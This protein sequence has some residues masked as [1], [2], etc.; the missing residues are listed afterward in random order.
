MLAACGADSGA[1]AQLPSA[2]RR[3]DGPLYV[4]QG[5][6]GAA[7]QVVQCRNGAIAGGFER[8]GVYAEGATSET[9]PDALE[10]AYSEGMFLE[11]PKVD[12]AVART[13]TDR[14]LLTYADDA[15]AVKVAIV[16][17]DGPGTEGAG[18]DGWYR[19]SWARCDLS[20]FPEQ[21][22]RSYFGYQIWTGADGEPALT[23]AIV[24]FPGSEHCGW[25][26]TTFLSLGEGSRDQALYAR[27]PQP[28]LEPL[29]QGKY[30]A[31]M[32]LPDDAVPT[33]YSRN[34]Q[35]LWLSADQQFAYVGEPRSV[36]AWPRTKPGF[37][38]A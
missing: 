35:R 11:M 29:M 3:Y 24:S 33:P 7:G 25:Q 9:V 10:T 13:E 36:E 17:H 38:C 37:G 28:D 27:H 16:F 2:E 4:A 6:Y 15:G 34:G 14:V 18:G 19:E 5:R 31:D 12:L 21:V 1:T 20:E 22:A 23:T 8:A 26:H 32:P 30:I